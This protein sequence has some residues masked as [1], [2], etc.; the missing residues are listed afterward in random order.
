MKSQ[1]TERQA[2]EARQG[3][4]GRPVA[5]VLVASLVLALLGFVTIGLLQTAGVVPTL[6]II[7]G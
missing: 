7:D 5:K 4:R 6:G 1:H 2:E 3:E